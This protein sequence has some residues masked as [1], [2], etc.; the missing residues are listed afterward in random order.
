M[1][2]KPNTFSLFAKPSFLSG[3]A[4]LL[5]WDNNFDQYNIIYRNPSKAD[6]EALKNDWMTVGNDLRLSMEYFQKNHEQ[7]QK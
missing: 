7:K 1:K 4:R 3:V 2:L 6:Y 5:D